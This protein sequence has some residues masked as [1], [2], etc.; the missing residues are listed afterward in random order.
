MMIMATVIIS[1]MII[2]RKTIH[3]VDI[4]NDNMAL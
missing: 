2:E 3:H 4:I 1:M